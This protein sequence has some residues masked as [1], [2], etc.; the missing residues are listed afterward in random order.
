MGSACDESKLDSDF[1]ALQ[2]Q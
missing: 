2:R 1:R